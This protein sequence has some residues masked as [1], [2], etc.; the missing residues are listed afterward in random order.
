MQAIILAGGK[1]TRLLPHTANLPKPLMPMGEMPILE[2]IVMQLKN[3]GASS[4]I[5]AVGYLHHMIE[6]HFGDG[7]DFGIPISYS[8]EDKPLGTAGPLNLIYKKLEENFIVLNGDLLTT[9]NFESLFNEHLRS[10][11][12]AT[13][14]TFKRTVDIDFGVLEID[15][16]K[17]LVEYKEK[18]TLNYQV[19]MGINV[20]KKNSLKNFLQNAGYLDI[21]DLMMELKNNGEDVLC[22][23]E[24]CEWLDIG[25]IDDYSIAT[26]IFKENKEKFLPKTK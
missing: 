22:H 5:M 8:L 16:E 2:I 10:N 4:I 19:S 21:P 3:A 18:P 17:K 15:S 1:G 26:E 13:I 14:A 24:D 25:R 20:F 23:Y 11:A 6:A 9:L 7:S 12:S